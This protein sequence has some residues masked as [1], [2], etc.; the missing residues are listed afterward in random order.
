MEFLVRQENKMPVMPAEEAAAIKAAEQSYAQQLRDQGIL[1]RL[2]RIP[3][4]RTALGLYEA[5]DATVLH[6][7]L[8]QLPTF[9]WQTLTVEAL[10]THPQEKQ[11]AL[12]LASRTATT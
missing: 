8:A 4:T 11:L 5:E 9:P 1:L 6:E 2:W 3:G 12:A 10:A 7:A